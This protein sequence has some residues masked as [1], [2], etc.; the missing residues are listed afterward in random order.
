MVKNEIIKTLKSIQ[1]EV[2]H[3]YKADI[4]GI[5]GSY[6]RGEENEDS[7]LDILVEFIEN[8]TLFDLVGLGDF[9]EEKLHCKVDI[10]S[11]RAVREEIK[12]YI[13]QDM[14]YI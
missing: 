13:N 7:D 8:A 10:A 1:S 4:K 12:Q 2:Y 9:L 14:V 5:F 11:K 6:A 3:K